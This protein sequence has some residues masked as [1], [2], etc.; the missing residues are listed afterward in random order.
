MSLQTS[1]A[2]RFNPKIRD[3]GL[4]YFRAGEVRILEHSDYHVLAQVGGTLDYLVEL[5]LT[6]HSLEALPF[7]TMGNKL[8]QF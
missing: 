1:F 6:L 5:T 4:A 7:P 2:S 3:L 8:S